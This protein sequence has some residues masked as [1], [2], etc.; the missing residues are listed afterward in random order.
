MKLLSALALA[1]VAVGCSDGGTS[2]APVASSS[3]SSTSSSSSSSTSSSSSSGGEPDDPLLTARPYERTVPASYDASKPAPLVMLLHGYTSNAKD[4]DAYF[5]IS[6][7]AETK[8]FLV[9]LPN[10]TKDAAGNP[11][12][13]ATDAC[14]NFVNAAVDDV[15][16]LRAVLADM[17]LRYA[18]DPKRVYVVGH[19]NGGFMSHR[20]ACELAGEIAAIVS[21]AGGQFADAT[22][23]TPSAPVAVLQV[24]GD[25][26]ETVTYEGGV[27]FG[28]SYPS[29]KQTVA[30]WAAKNGCSPTLEPARDALDLERTLAGAETT[31]ARHACTTG[32]AELWTIAG[33]KHV[34]TFAQPAWA[35][36][37]YSFLDAHP[38][39]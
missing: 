4:Q 27:F 37:V 38:K 21:L 30:T 12:W 35:E 25:Q 33:G 20:L 16:Y 2:G 26:D 32:A 34:P 11:F 31:V 1:F 6:A 28:K 36:A 23:C 3:S 7:L 24:H 10:G 13:A 9:A 18:V 5:G 17:K 8:G 22:K 29:A 14:C 15:A 19:S 39:P